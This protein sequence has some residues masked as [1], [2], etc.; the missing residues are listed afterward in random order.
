[1]TVAKMTSKGQTVIPKPIRQHLNLHPGD[2]ID[3]VVDE[4]GRVIVQPLDGDVTALRGALRRPGRKAVSLSEM[5]QAIRR[6]AGR[7]A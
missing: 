5:Q 3:F 4:E 6:R 1:M 7:M 2:R